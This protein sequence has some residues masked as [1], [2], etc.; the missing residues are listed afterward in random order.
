[1]KS[2]KRARTLPQTEECGVWLDASQLKKKSHQA[3]IPCTSSRF[4]PL[5]RRASMDSVLVE[6]TQTVLPQLCTKQTSMYAFFSPAGNRNKQSCATDIN[7]LAPEREKTKVQ[8]AMN[9]MKPSV[10]GAAMCLMKT[11]SDCKP[12]ENQESAALYEIH[13]KTEKPGSSRNNENYELSRV[14]DKA[15]NMDCSFSSVFRSQDSSVD[16]TVS[17][18]A[19]GCHPK[20]KNHVSSVYT[21][22]QEDYSKED[23]LTSGLMESQLFTQ[24]TQ[25]NRVI[26]HRFTGERQMNAAP[27]QDRTNV[28]WDTKSLI[29]GTLQSLHDEDS[30]HR[31]FTQDSEGNVVIKH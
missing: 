19:A 14:L 17:P 18:R 16:P 30:L 13:R 8:E 3:V 11:Y 21:Y 1:M 26:C 25:G 2:R 29:K 31:M 12:V 22:P 6:F 27:L 24:D 7:T 23:R 10:V 4:H 9:L 20:H 28:S 5:S 15:E